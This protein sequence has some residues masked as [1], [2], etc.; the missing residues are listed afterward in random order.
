[1]RAFEGMWTSTGVSESLW[2]IARVV[3]QAPRVSAV[4]T[5]RRRRLVAMEPLE[6]LSVN[7]WELVRLRTA[8]ISVD[9][10][11]GLGGT[12][13]S[14]RRLADGTEL[15]YRTP[16]G[17][18]PYGSSLLPGSS[19]A[20]MLATYPGGWQTLFPNG[21][22]TSIV[23]GVEWGH[24]GETRIAP[25]AW[26]ETEPASAGPSITLTS[27]LVRAPFEVTKVIALD[28]DRVSVAER[29][30]NVSGESL[31]VVWGQQIALGEPLIGPDSVVDAAATT[32]HPDPAVTSD[33]SYD[34][35]MP[36]PRSFGE[37]GVLNLRNLPAPRSAQTRLA[38]VTDFRAPTVTVTNQ[39]LDLKVDLAWD[40]DSWPYLWYSMEAGGR[41]GFPWFSDGYFLSLTPSSSWPAHGVHDARR[42]AQSTMWIHPAETKHSQ[43]TLTVGSAD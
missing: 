11:P 10:L 3:S 38:Y 7:G 1:M 28:R 20:Q 29:V 40:G 34:D 16:W 21:G 41:S 26:R 32:V 43:L 35:V 14:V 9:V 36:W 18:R 23:H 42:V 8:L 22:D 31:E 5:R 24:D 2:T 37:P 39:A 33:T 6:H 4:P 27:R 19:E 12:I 30:C 13:V 25:F 15:L 17:I